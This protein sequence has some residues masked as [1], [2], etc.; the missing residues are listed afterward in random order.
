MYEIFILKDE[1]V[2]VRLD[3]R[4]SRRTKF[5][6]EDDQRRHR[7]MF[8]VQKNREVGGQ[9]SSL[10]TT[11][12]EDEDDRIRTGKTK[13][14]DEGSFR[15][16]HGWSSFRI[17]P[18]EV[19]GGYAGLTDFTVPFLTFDELASPFLGSHGH[20]LLLHL[21]VNILSF[22]YPYLLD[23]LLYVPAYI[24]EPGE[25]AKQLRNSHFPVEVEF[26]PELRMLE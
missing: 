10:E 21:S 7:K 20:F 12:E 19:A 5:V 17:S 3:E 22:T 9:F 16:L 11:L 14:S 15:S 8:I 26:V 1:V 25:A 6:I 24:F 18:D 13:I 23:L 4:R 2:S